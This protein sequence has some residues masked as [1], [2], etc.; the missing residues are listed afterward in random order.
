[1]SWHTLSRPSCQHKSA[2]RPWEARE[3]WGL[4]V[5]GLNCGFQ[6]DGICSRRP[7]CSGDPQ[8]GWSYGGGTPGPIRSHGDLVHRVGAF[9]VLHFADYCMV[10]GWSNRTHRPLGCNHNRRAGGIPMIRSVAFLGEGEVYL[11]GKPILLQQWP[12]GDCQQEE[13]VSGVYHPLLKLATS[14]VWLGT[15]KK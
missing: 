5:E 4:L 11:R 13:V 8:L 1:M 6:R 2:H 7:L 12:E 14:S 9:L 15:I 3:Q 10:G